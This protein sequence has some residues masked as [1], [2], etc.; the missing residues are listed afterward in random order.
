MTKKGEITT[1]MRWIISGKVRNTHI[2][3][4]GD[5]TQYLTEQNKT[6]FKQ[7]LLSSSLIHTIIF[8]K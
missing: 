3:V 7:T 2:I 1:T 4:F 6:A 8:N 5:R